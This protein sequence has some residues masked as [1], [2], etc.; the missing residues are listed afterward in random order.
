MLM[1]LKMVGEA[2]VV[3]TIGDLITSTSVMLRMMLAA[4]VMAVVLFFTTTMLNARSDRACRLFEIS[5]GVVT[6]V[7]F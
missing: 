3:M 1:M 7:P 4:V 5:G 6:Q 2:A